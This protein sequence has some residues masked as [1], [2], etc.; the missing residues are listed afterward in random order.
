M[1]STTGLLMESVH[2]LDELRSL[3]S[4]FP[5]DQHTFR[6]NAKN[7]TW[8][9]PDT[10]ALAGKIWDCLQH[11]DSIARMI[12]NIQSNEASIYMVLSEMKRKGLI[13]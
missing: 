5:D 4:E 8:E 9:D 1:V 11:Q 6:L 2:L 12:R 13:S 10:L 7:L 3:K